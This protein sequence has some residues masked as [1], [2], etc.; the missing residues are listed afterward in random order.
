MAYIE[1]FDAPD[2]PSLSSLFPRTSEEDSLSVL[3]GA[4]GA[5]LRFGSYSGILSPNSKKEKGEF[6][7]FVVP[8]QAAILQIFSI[9]RTILTE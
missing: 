6:E 8:F 9:M 5:T 7:V 2:A 3:F 4:G 1:A